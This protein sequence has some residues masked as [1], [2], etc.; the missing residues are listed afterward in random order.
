MTLALRAATVDDAATITAH[1]RHMF[2]AMGG[3]DS[4]GLDA[5]DAAFEPWVRARLESG[6]YRGWLA[7][8]GEA[9]VAGAGLWVM[10]WA[11]GPVDPADRRGVVYNVYTEPAYRGRGLARRLMV[12]LLDYCRAQCITTV[13]L[14]ASDAGRPLY[15]SL[16]FQGTN[17]MRLSL[18]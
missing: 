1:R 16:G 2:E 15:E 6:A 4:A 9:I 3:Y 14:H 12:A 13:V 17:E 7:L 8:D 5:M 18:R 11:P 10:P